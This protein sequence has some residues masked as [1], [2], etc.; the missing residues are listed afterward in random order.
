MKRTL[1]VSIVQN[2]PWKVKTNGIQ[3]KFYIVISDIY[4]ISVKM[5]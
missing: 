2:L 4:A 3:I 5:L 1:G